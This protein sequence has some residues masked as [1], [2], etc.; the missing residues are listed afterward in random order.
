MCELSVRPISGIVASMSDP[1][2]TTG[3]AEEV[4]PLLRI[5]QLTVPR[6]EPARDGIPPDAEQM[7][8][9][10]RVATTVP[11]HGG[12]RPW[13]FVVVA[14]DAR[15]RF[16]EALANGLREE[17]GPDAP[18][19]MVTKM[20]G[21]AFAAPCAVVLIAAPVRG[22]NIA[23][24][25]QFAS[26]SCTGYAIVL[27]ANALGLGSVWK[28]A[29]V[30]HTGAV[31]TFFDLDDDEQVIGWVNLGSPTMGGRR[32]TVGRPEPDLAELVSV[33]DGH[34]SAPFGQ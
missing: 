14:G 18:Q 2:T 4:G 28:S 27:A 25:E 29:H 21:K 26:A 17:R 19:A 5:D 32:T 7:A 30:L 23:G 9:I 10:L 33:M 34:G 6:P 12:L 15:Q 31:R 20:H 1:G 11:D 13:R 24:W 8:R 22:S 3:G 16:G